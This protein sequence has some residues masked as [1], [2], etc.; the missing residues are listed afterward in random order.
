MCYAP[1][2]TRCPSLSA[3]QAGTHLIVAKPCKKGTIYDHFCVFYKYATSKLL[4]ATWI[5]RGRSGGQ[6][7]PAWLQSLWT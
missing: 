3:L 7:Q 4:E 5:V 1:V 2:L 6:A